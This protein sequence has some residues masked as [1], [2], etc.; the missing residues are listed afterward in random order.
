MILKVKK[1]HKDAIIPK[2]QTTGSAGFDL[3]ALNDVIIYPGETVI[4]DTGLAFD[5]P[6]NHE[7]QI[8]PRS[9]ISAKTKLR[10]SNA[11]GTIDEDYKGNVKII[12][13]NIDFKKNKRLYTTIKK[14]ERICQAK[15]V[16]VIR[17]EFVEVEELSET[18][19]GDKGIGSTGL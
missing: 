7:I 17:A 16:P 2:Y 3:H 19:R 15:L 4:V 14:G 6:E 12:L 18:E 13:D 9:G 1:M 5:I 8:V 11:P 10:I